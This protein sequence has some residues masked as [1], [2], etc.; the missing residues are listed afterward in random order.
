MEKQCPTSSCTGRGRRTRH[1]IGAA[2]YHP[3]SVRRFAPA[4]KRLQ[5]T[6]IHAIKLACPPAADPQPRY[7]TSYT[8]IVGVQGQ[9]NF[10][11]GK[12]PALPRDSQSLTFPGVDKPG[13]IRKP[14]S[15][16]PVKVQ[17]RGGFQWTTSKSMGNGNKVLRTDFLIK[18]P[19]GA[20]TPSSFSECPLSCSGQG[21]PAA[22]YVLD[23]QDIRQVEVRPKSEVVFFMICRSRRLWP[24]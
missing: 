24:K 3:L 22:E 6:V 5:R 11:L 16:E 2:D 7:G 9:Y 21:Q 14:P 4:I 13:K 17:E 1:A 19:H 8:N 20:K 15:C 10:L 12:P 23:A 18:N